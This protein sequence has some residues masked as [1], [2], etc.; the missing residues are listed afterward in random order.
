MLMRRYGSDS[1]CGFGK[2]SFGQ[3]KDLLKAVKGQ[4]AELKKKHQLRWVAAV[5]CFIQAQIDSN[6]L[7]EQAVEGVH[8]SILSTLP[9]LFY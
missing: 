3:T 7:P 8:I 4:A 2:K 9:W 6:I 5:L 1:V